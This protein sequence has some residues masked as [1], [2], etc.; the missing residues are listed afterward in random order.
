MRISDWSSDVC[1]SDLIA[2]TITAENF[3]RSTSPPSTSATVMAEKV[4]WKAMNTN[5][6]ITTPSVKVATVESAAK[7]A[8]QY[9]PAELIWLAE[10]PKARPSTKINH[11]IMALAGKNGRESGR[12]R[13]TVDGE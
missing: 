11:M 7:P 12:E 10:S 8:R 2:K 3:M 6:G 4:I 13:V 5:S 1:S 9:V